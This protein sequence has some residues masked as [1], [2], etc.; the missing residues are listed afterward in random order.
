MFL[1]YLFDSGGTFFQHKTIRRLKKKYRRYMDYKQFNTEDFI[2]DERFVNWVIE[3]DEINEAFWN[4]WLAGNPEKKASVEEAKAFILSMNHKVVHPSLEAKSRILDKIHEGIAPKE[5]RLSKSS[6]LPF[7]TLAKVAA[8]VLVVLGAYWYVN[9]SPD[10]TYQT[11]YGDLEQIVLPDGSK[12]VLNANSRM[13][14]TDNWKSDAKREVWLKG[15][16]Y[17]DVAKSKD[18]V[19]NAFVVHTPDVDINVLGT[20]FNVNARTANVDV[21]LEEGLVEIAINNEVDTK[22]NATHQLIP[23]YKA[24]YDASAKSYSVEEVETN[25]YTAWKEG[26]LV[27]NNTSLEEL[28]SLIE[29]T[30]GIKVKIANKDLKNKRLDGTIDN[31]DLDTVLSALEAIFN[32]KI[33]KKSNEITILK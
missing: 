9:L 30:H 29:Q 33:Y 3:P 7:A 23:G 16:A 31:T 14:Y 19:K 24:S 10:K 18:G 26:K 25:V 22:T 20:A 4:N 6:S 28:K 21:V 27:F 2:A 13:K 15:E 12:V 11:A 8:I 17:F 1:H 5:H 32:L